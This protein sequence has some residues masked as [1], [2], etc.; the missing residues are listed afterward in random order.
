MASRADLAAVW[1]PTAAV[2]KQA[3]SAVKA[4]LAA[5]RDRFN[6]REAA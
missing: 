6:V 1:P 3:A 4:E 2:A 5:M